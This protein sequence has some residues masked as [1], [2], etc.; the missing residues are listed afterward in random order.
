MAGL[1]SG[2]N[3]DSHVIFLDM[4][5]T[6]TW[7]GEVV[8]ENLAAI[9]RAQEAGHKVVLNTGRSY[10]FIPRR[11]L[12]TVPFDGVIA[13]G[14]AYIRASNTPLLR[15]NL[16]PTDD[17]LVLLNAVIPD[18]VLKEL[19]DWFS[20]HE[21]PIFFE[22]VRES[23]CM[24]AERENFK[25]IS[26]YEDIDSATKITIFSTIAGPLPE[27]GRALIEQYFTYI[28]HPRYSEGILHG[29][30]KA[31]GMDIYLTHVG[32]PLSRSIAMGDSANDMDMLRHAGISVGM[33]DST[34]E[35]LDCVDYVSANCGDGGVARAI[36]DLLKV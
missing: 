32:I 5:N 28:C 29:Y 12:L 18:S 30:S 9:R 33:G 24:N 22:G 1:K 16:S 20:E 36:Y 14:G 31:S 26:G 19:C 7:K 6:L 8:P 10:G 27:D 3:M 11:V 13:G 2:C 15:D 35:V 25:L 34:R 21:L 23:Y 4:D 17:D